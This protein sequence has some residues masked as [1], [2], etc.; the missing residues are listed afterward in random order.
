VSKQK[1][2]SATAL[3]TVPAGGTGQGGLCGSDSYEVAARLT[4]VMILL[5]SGNLWFHVVP[6]RVLALAGLVYM[7]LVRRTTYWLALFLLS[8]AVDNLYNWAIA[9]NH[10]WL[11]SYWLLALALSV[12]SKAPEATLS[13]SARLLIGFAFLL[14]TLRKAMSPQ[15]L[16]GRAFQ[17]LLMADPRFYHVALFGDHTQDIPAFWR[18]ML[19]LSPEVALPVVTPGFQRIAWVMTW[20]TIFIEG[21]IALAFLIRDNPRAERAR[22]W[23]L[24]TFVITTYPVAPVLGF[25]WLLLI[26][27][28]AQC[29]LELRAARFAYLL[30][31]P[32]VYLFYG[33]F[34]K[35]YVFEWWGM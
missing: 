3:D 18:E 8:F 31:F 26:M 30:M 21:A 15:Y 29:S 19:N 4:L 13:Q 10:H 20:W 24:L 7:P 11:L 22:N 1:F 6:I 17:F 2:Q 16:D 12:G 25:A 32:L 33:E 9:D 35:K 27:G 34:V 23:L 14:A 28:W 5:L